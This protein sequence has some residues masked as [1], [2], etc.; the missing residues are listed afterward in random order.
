VSLFRP[1]ISES[2]ELNAIE[3]RLKQEREDLEREKQACEIV[4][5]VMD[6]RA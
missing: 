1:F 5:V 6:L 3:K 4:V 2:G